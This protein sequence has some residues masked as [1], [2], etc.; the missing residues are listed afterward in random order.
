MLTT[1]FGLVS[2]GADGESEERTFV[3]AEEACDGLFA[4][5]LA[6]QVEAVTG[7]TEF[8]AT[9]NKGKAMSNVVNALKRGYAAGRS[10]ATGADLCELD[11][12]GGGLGDGAGIKFSMYA[13]QDVEEPGGPAGA[14]LYTMGK[15]SEVRE[16]G[17]SLYLECVSPQIKG[18]EKVP[19]RIYGGF[20]RGESDA[21]DSRRFRNANM[22]I[23]HAGALALVKELGCE[24]DAGLPETPVLTPK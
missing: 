21:P 24:R 11:P 6:K 20:G 22:E 14:E 16:G 9:G 17:A 1:G 12:K 19:L 3:G 5:P 4:G 7:D 13:P 18:S 15:K 8:F 10:S 2:C 23:L